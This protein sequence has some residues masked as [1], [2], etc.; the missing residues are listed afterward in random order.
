M[1]SLGLQAQW[2]YMITVIIKYQ[3]TKIISVRA[4]PDF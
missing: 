1:D 4:A 2:P 3:N